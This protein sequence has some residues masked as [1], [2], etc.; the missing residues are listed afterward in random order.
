MNMLNSALDVTQSV[1]RFFGE[2]FD[3]RLR[4]SS[5]RDELGRSR[6][7]RRLELKAPCVGRRLTQAATAPPKT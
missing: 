5:F 7:Y 3:G 2:L 4:L 6:E 1:W